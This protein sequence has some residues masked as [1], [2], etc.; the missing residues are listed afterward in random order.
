MP[1]IKASSSERGPCICFF[2]TFDFFVT[3]NDILKM[4]VEAARDII[5]RYG[6]LSTGHVT[7]KRRSG[8]QRVGLESREEEEVRMR[9]GGAESE[10]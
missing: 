10:G 6:P 7:V 8:G 3:N 1:Q 5:G 9:S 4:V 2:F